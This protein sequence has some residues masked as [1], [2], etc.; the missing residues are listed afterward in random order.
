MENPTDSDM[1]VHIFK[2]VSV[3]KSVVDHVLHVKV[4]VLMRIQF[5]SLC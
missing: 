4:Q 3:P 5:D 1:R 2:Y